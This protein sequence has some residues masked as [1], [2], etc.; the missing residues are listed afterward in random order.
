MEQGR[1]TPT[2]SIEEL[3]DLLEALESELDKMPPV[4]KL[5]ARALRDELERDSK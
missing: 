5:W 3:R 1:E 2:L 4:V